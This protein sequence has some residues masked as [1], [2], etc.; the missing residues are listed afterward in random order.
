MNAARVGDHDVPLG[1]PVYDADGERVGTVAGAEDD[2]LVVD[3]GE[4]FVDHVPMAAAVGFDGRAVR[5]AMTT[6][7]VVRGEAERIC[8]HLPRT[9]R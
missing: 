7:E 5:L 8:R 4:V 1:C 9:R 2:C 3:H 6:E